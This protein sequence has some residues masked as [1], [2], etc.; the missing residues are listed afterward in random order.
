M[1]M[2]FFDR[3]QAGQALAQQLAH[4]VEESESG[5]VLAL[6]RGGVPIGYEIICTLNWPLDVWLVRKLG[7]PDQPEL[8]MGALA[9]PHAQ[10]LNKGLIEKLQVSE[11]DIEAVVQTE[12]QELHRRHHC[13]RQEKPLPVLCGKPIIVVDDGLATGATMQAA[14]AALK[15]YQ[16]SSITVAVPIA[17]SSSLKPIEEQVDRVICPLL[18][19]SMGSISQ[20]YDHFEPV[21]DT[22]VVTLLEQAEA[23]QNK[24]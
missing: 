3:R 9:W 14:I 2:K 19:K 13:Y 22:E 8:A 23:L 15:P 17:A 6:P 11:R 21:D 10:V 12:L 1:G 5:I 4:V 24:P 20:W 18:P 16:P 7:V